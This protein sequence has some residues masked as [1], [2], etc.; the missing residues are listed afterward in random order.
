M[1]RE[2]TDMLSTALANVRQ[3]RIN[4]LRFRL[5]ENIKTED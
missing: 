4:P 1:S 2:S 5:D 3:N